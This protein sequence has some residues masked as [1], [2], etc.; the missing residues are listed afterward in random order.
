M[1]YAL[2]ILTIKLWEWEGISEKAITSIAK[3]GPCEENTVQFNTA[4][5]R[6]GE[7]RNAINILNLK[8][9]D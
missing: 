6:I 4:A 2:L 5:E 7:L 8:P 3:D 9:N 1:K